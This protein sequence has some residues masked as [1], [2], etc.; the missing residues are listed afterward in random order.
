MSGELKLILTEIAKGLQKATETASDFAV[1]QAPVLAQEIV[2]QGIVTAALRFVF[3]AL[4]LVGDVLVLKYLWGSRGVLDEVLVVGG[5]LLGGFAL[6]LG[7]LGIVA[8]TKTIL[9]TWLAPRLYVLE[10]I[11]EIIK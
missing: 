10:Y 7:L 2:T 5:S 3:Y 8:S 11:K 6:L 1:D 9:S 4:L